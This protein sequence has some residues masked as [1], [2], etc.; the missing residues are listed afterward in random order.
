VR[1][2]GSPDD[3]QSVTVSSSAPRRR[4]D[5]HHLRKERPG[6]WRSVRVKNALVT[7]DRLRVRVP[8]AFDAVEIS[9]TTA[10]RDVAVELRRYDGAKVVTRKL[11]QQRVPARRALR[12]GPAD[13][14]RLSRS[15][16]EQ[17]LA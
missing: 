7:S 16:I 5:I 9:G 3:D 4:F 8:V 6:A 11:T 15:K 10:R 13:W 14:E 2:E 17:V 1:L 12:M